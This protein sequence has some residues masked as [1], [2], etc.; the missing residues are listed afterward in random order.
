MDN[1]VA[2]II[3][4]ILTAAGGALVAAGYLTSEEWV[5]IAGALAVL[6]GVMWSVISRRLTNSRTSTPS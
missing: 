4:H 3:R 2:G 6:L 5:A 1:I